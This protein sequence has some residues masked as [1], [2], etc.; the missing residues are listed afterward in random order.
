MTKFK[1]F[2]DRGKTF[3]STPPRRWRRSNICQNHDRFLF[4]STPPRRWWHNPIDYI[5]I[6]G[7]FQS[8]PPRRWWLCFAVL[9]SGIQY[10]NP[11]HREG[12][13]PEPEPDPAPDPISIHTTAKVVTVKESEI[14]LFIDISIHTTAKVVT[15][16]SSSFVS[17]CR[18]QSTPPRRWWPYQCTAL[19]VKAYISIHTTA[20]VV[21]NQVSIPS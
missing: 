4:Q 12:G 9:K 17:L 8:P 14:T 1:L 16:T 20:K 7:R 11:H 18:F 3:Q 21:T 19:P 5:L 6:L 15:L 10:F 13:D 2:F